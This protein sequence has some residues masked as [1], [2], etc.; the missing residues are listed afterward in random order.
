MVI[1]EKNVVLWSDQSTVG[2]RKRTKKCI[3]QCSAKSVTNK[4]AYASLH[5]CG[6]MACIPYK[7]T[8][9]YLKTNKTPKTTLLFLTGLSQELHVPVISS[10]FFSTGDTAGLPG[11]KESNPKVT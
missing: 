7:A 1:I 8:I 3:H 2:K 11:R 10:R 6:N 5:L 4:L 9:P